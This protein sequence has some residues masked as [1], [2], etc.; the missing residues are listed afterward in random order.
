MSSLLEQGEWSG[1]VV[2]DGV[3]VTIGVGVIGV[4]WV[5]AIIFTTITIAITVAIAITITITVNFITLLILMHN[6][7][8]FSLPFHPLPAFNPITLPPPN[9]HT[10]VPVVFVSDVVGKLLS[11]FLWG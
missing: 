2:R 11:L 7:N 8:Q 10:L 6:P 5:I 9:R 4:T 1:G 3:V